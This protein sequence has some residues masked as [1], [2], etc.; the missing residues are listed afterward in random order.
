MSAPVARRAALASDLRAHAFALPAGT[1][2]GAPRIGAE[3]ELLPV[4]RATRRLAPI[5]GSAP[6]SSL[7]LLREIGAPRGWAERASDKGVPVFVLP[8]GAGVTFEPGGQVEYSSPPHHS[9]SVVIE[10]MQSFAAVFTEAAERRELDVLAVGIDPVH[11]VD[12]APLQLHAPRYERMA[13]FFATI[14][15]AGARMMRQT[16][17][18]QVN[19][20]PP[21]GAAVSAWRLLNTLAP[22]LTAIFANSPRYGGRITGHRSFR[23]HCW[24][25]LDPGRTGLVGLTGDPIDAY[26]EFALE[27]RALLVG[28]G[29]SDYPVFGD[30]VERPDADESEWHVHLT[31]LFPEVRPRGRFEVRSIDALPPRWYAAP[32]ALVAGLLY[33]RDGHRAAAEIAAGADAEL[34]CRGGREGLRDPAIARPA[35]ALFEL[36]LSACRRLGPAILS[37]ADLASATDFFETYTRRGRSPAD[38][39]DEAD[40][41]RG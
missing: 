6:G 25:S 26:L 27:A 11:T 35:V 16:A 8:D 10:R 29:P 4:E 32:I 23:A 19:V 7:A 5:F 9:A 3:L 28:S 24:R 34:L 15:P 2:S 1:V 20:D 18:I 31:T 22:Y 17:S 21:G 41:L 13:G 36:A 30:W 39:Q 14:G 33:D 40:A 12:A 37:G 38:D